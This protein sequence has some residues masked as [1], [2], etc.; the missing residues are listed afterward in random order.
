MPEPSSAPETSPLEEPKPAPK[1]TSSDAGH[2]PLTEEMDSAKWRLPPVLPVVASALVLALVFGIFA[3]IF[4]R[5]VATGQILTVNSAE[6][7]T[8]D[9][10]LVG[11]NV[12]VKNVSKDVLYIKTIHAEMMPAGQNND[13]SLLKDDAASAV[14]FDRYFEAYPALAQNKMEPL[15]PET[16][17]QPG[18][19]QQGMV[20]VAF[21]V[22]QQAF[23]Q[24][25]SL[26]VLIDFYNHSIPA[27]L[28]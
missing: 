15:R 17:L 2:L 20:I 19:S 22:N 11:L 14:D 16:K 27:K 1:R 4:T 5:P 10:V 8:R 6:Q 21:R 12:T 7:A 3:W 18:E 9:S 26:R 23:N 28:Q 24:R 13:E 25:Q